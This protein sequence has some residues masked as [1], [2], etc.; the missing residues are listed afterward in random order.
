MRLSAFPLGRVRSVTAGNEDPLTFGYD[1]DG[2]AAGVGLPYSVSAIAPWDGSLLVGMVQHDGFGNPISA[3]GPGPN[4]YLVTGYLNNYAGV[5]QPQRIT[6]ALGHTTAL[7][8]ADSHGNCTSLTDPLGATVTYNYDP[9]GRLKQM[10]DGNGTITTVEY[11]PETHFPSSVTSTN[12]SLGSAV[13]G[14][15]Y[16]ANRRPWKLS[17][18]AGQ[19]VLGWYGNSQV[20]RSVTTSYNSVNTYNSTRPAESVAYS[21]KGDGS[22]DMLFTPAGPVKYGYDDGGRLNSLRDAQGKTTT[23]LYNDDDTLAYQFLPNDMIS[24]L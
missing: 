17:D 7:G 24:Q 16:D 23:W 18:P 13:T 14:L 6:D 9:V 11:D 15:L 22:L 5:G 1:D 12:P 20:L 4:G 3:S 19:D 8:F 10:T 2:G 21:Y